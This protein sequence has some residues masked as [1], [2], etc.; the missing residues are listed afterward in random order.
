[1]LPQPFLALPQLKVSFPL[2]WCQFR[3]V[4]RRMIDNGYPGD[5]RTYPISFL[6]SLTVIGPCTDFLLRPPEGSTISYPHYCFHCQNGM[7]LFPIPFNLD[8]NATRGRYLSCI[9]IRF[10][11]SFSPLIRR[12]NRKN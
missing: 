9:H 7:S 11:A 10:G 3:R 1:M 5:V 12:A 8:A 4:D 6:S 2:R